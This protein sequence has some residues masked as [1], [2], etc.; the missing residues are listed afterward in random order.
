M[1]ETLTHSVLDREAF[2]NSRV[3]EGISKY[4]TPR[5]ISLIHEVPKDAQLTPVR[6]GRTR[7]D[8]GTYGY[9]AAPQF[10][11]ITGADGDKKVIGS[12][13]M[14][15]EYGACMGFLLN[16]PEAQITIQLTR[17]PNRG[18]YHVFTSTVL[19]TLQR[20]P[21]FSRTDVFLQYLNKH[22]SLDTEVYETLTFGLDGAITKRYVQAHQVRTVSPDMSKH[23]RVDLVG[24]V[25]L[26][27]YGPILEEI[28][29]A[30][31]ELID[32]SSDQPQQPT[33]KILHTNHVRLQELP[34][35]QNYSPSLSGNGVKTNH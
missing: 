24:T 29:T 4:L 5:Q 16:V 27:D 35:L 26:A 1:I 25:I 34:S 13:V 22:F 23:T 3:L 12:F 11:E 32:Y 31:E 28:T 20:M 18:E 33:Y 19:Q 15:D 21:L 17:D 6:G 2:A 30:T 9:L 14:Y 7:L 10:Q 8:H